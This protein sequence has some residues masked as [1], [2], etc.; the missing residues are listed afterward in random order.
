MRFAVWLALLLLFTAPAVAQQ[1]IIRPNSAE[2]QGLGRHPRLRQ[3]AQ[4]IE[5]QRLFRAG[6]ITYLVFIQRLNQAFGIQNNY[7]ATIRDYRQAIT[8]LN[9]LRGQ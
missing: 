8:E 4:E 9:Y 6:E 5:E 1:L 2:A 7:L 3:S